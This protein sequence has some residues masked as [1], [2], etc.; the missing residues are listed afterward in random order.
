MFREHRPLW[1]EIN[2]DN[3][4]SNIRSIKSLLKPGTDYISVVKADGYGHGAVEVAK[5]CMECGI[6]RLAVAM[7]DEA[8]ELRNAGIK[9]NI[10]ILG[11]TPSNMAD[12]IVE[13]DISQTC[14]SYELAKALSD[15]GCRLGKTAKIHIAV[16]TGMGRIGFQPSFDDAL[17]VKE[18]SKLPNLKI[19]GIF[20][21]FA[22]ADE[23]DKLYTKEQFKKYKAFLDIL[24]SFKVDVGIKHVGNSAEIL[25]LP[26]FNLDAVR[27]GI[28][29]YGLYPSDEVTKSKLDLKPVMSVKANIIHV[30]E[31]EK[32]TS[33][34]YGRKYITT[35]KSK[36]ATLPIGYADGYTRLLFGKARVII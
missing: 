13:N 34:S 4:A 7:L 23:K 28:I 20:T 30:K 29:Q 26:D 36:I 31:V 10:L 2:L 35:R 24:K 25:D 18:I 9:C 33:I 5:T 22:V 16:D 12:T 14:Y 6:N 32:G 19:E 15:A 8:L 3:L 17:I 11:Y 27:P 21:H 1:V